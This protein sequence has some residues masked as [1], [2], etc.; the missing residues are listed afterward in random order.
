[1][2]A[3]GE[4][5]PCKIGSSVATLVD[6]AYPCAIAGPVRGRSIEVAGA[7][8]V[9]VASLPLAFQLVPDW[10][11]ISVPPGN[12][13]DLLPMRRHYVRRRMAESWKSRSGNRTIPKCAR[14]R[15]VM[16]RA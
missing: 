4:V 10:L 9:A 11:A 16:S 6:V 15:T 13:Y 5:E 7:T 12:F 8:P 2:S 3:D 1:M 14:R